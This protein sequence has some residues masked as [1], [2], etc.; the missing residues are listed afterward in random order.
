VLVKFTTTAP[1]VDKKDESGQVIGTTNG[2]YIVDA[3]ITGVNST[4]NLQVVN[5]QMAEV[6]TGATKYIAE[7]TWSGETAAR[8]YV[9]QYDGTS[10]QVHAAPSGVTTTTTYPAYAV[11]T[12]DSQN[13]NA[14]SNYMTFGSWLLIPQTSLTGVTLE[15][16]YIVDNVLVNTT[17]ELGTGVSTWAYGMQTTYNV[18]IT[19][20][21]ITF[22]PIV[23]EWTNEGDINHGDYEEET[24]QTVT[25]TEVENVNYQPADG[26]ASKCVIRYEGTLQVGTE[27]FV[28]EGEN[29]NSAP[30]GTYTF[31]E[32]EAA[33]VLVVE[34]KGVVKAINPGQQA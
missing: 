29:Y 17:F 18:R 20:E 10:E 9:A 12:Y 27:V 1:V 16:T 25:Y 26:T 7:F 11:P 23:E 24:Q 28:K 31:G 6:T 19:P 15:V 22:D 32:G 14:A 5:R 21:Y 30:A 8:S 2:V 34:E 33:T 3:K 4:A 13:P